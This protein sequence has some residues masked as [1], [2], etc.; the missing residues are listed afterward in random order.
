MPTIFVVDPKPASVDCLATRLRRGGYSVVAMRDP[1]EA[2]QSLCSVRADLL[3]VDVRG[4]GMRRPAV[5]ASLRN[6]RAYRTMAV[7]V[8][9]RGFTESRHIKASSA[10]GRSQLTHRAPDDLMKRVRQIVAPLAWPCN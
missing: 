9:G 8:V 2:V 3:V 4:T 10:A 6:R 1:E 7:I 5:L